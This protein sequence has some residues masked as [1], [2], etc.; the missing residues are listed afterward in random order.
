MFR[1]WSRPVCVSDG[2]LSTFWIA[3]QMIPPVERCVLAEMDAMKC[4]VLSTCHGKC[5]QWFWITWLWSGSRTDRQPDRET[6]AG[7]YLVLP[8]RLG[9]L[10][11][12]GVRTGNTVP[13]CSRPAQIPIQLC[14]GWVVTWTRQIPAVVWLGSTYSRASCLRTQNFG[15]N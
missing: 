1:F 15:S 6:T 8:T 10:P 9:N 11:M 3:S 4:I 2:D 5:S 13:F 14:L 12:V 7:L